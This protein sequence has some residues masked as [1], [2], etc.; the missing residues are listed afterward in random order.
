M[1]E[2]EGSIIKIAGCSYEGSL[3]GWSVGSAELGGVDDHSTIASSSKQKKVK[4]Q[5]ENVEAQ[6]KM[7]FGFHVSISSFKAIAISASGKYLAVAG[8][9]ERIHVYNMMTNKAMGEVAGHTGG[10]TSLVFVEDNFLLSGSEDHTLY[11]WRVYDWQQLHILGG[12]KDIVTD[13]AIHPS[14]KIALSISK[15]HTM[16]LWN[17]VQGRCSFTR[18]LR[19]MA[20]HILW[21][22]SGDYYLLMTNAEIQVFVVADNSCKFEVT[23]KSR[24]NHVTFVKS[25]VDEYRVVYICDNQTL[26]VIDMEGQALVTLNLTS[27]GAGRLKALCSCPSTGMPILPNDGNVQVTGEKSDCL[28][29]ATSTGCVAVLNAALLVEYA[30]KA[31]ATAEES[32][33]A[34]GK[35]LYAFDQIR[36]EPRLTSITAWNTQVS[37]AWKV[38]YNKENP[39]VEEMDLMKHEPIVMDSDD[40]EDEEEGSEEEEESKPQKKKHIFGKK[41]KKEEKKQPVVKA[42]KKPVKFQASNDNKS[43]NQGKKNKSKK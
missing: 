15:D 10:I 42:E 4:L 3:F 14:G 27:L 21:H 35:A 25:D 28:V 33:T 13:F 17:L 7:I 41:N 1:A 31:K 29:V 9:D 34:F 37:N 22:P 40:E 26:N 39:P 12:H 32:E 23:S 19:S 2:G 5:P 24:I 38:K 20:E 18:R 16:K 36:A 11:I 30:P 6:I 8:M 43:K